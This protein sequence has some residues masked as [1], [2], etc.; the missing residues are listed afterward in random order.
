[1]TLDHSVGKDPG[2]ARLVECPFC[3]EELAMEF[4]NPKY[5]QP[6]KH[7]RNCDAFRDT[8]RDQPGEP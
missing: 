4:D 8:L 3:G 7:L 5:K 6:A 2:Q 1:M